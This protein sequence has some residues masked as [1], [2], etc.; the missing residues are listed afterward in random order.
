MAFAI[1]HLHTRC[2]I[3]PVINFQPKF[4][5]SI[6]VKAT[7]RFSLYSGSLLILNLTRETVFSAVSPIK[8]EVGTMKSMKLII[9]IFACVLI[10]VFPVNSARAG[11]FGFFIGGMHIGFGYPFGFGYR[12]GHHKHHHGYYK[13]PHH[14][15]HGEHKKH[16]YRKHKKH[17][18]GHKYGEYGY[19]KDEYYYVK[20]RRHKNYGHFQHKPRNYSHWS[21]PRYYDKPK[22]RHQRTGF[23]KNRHWRHW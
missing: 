16:H 12:H 15:Y 18:Y 3:P 10:S 22:V 13:K 23:A 11:D 21:K 9:P 14:Y 1:G 19:G 8:A 20:P 17:H 7:S 6:A 2:V 4:E 5:L